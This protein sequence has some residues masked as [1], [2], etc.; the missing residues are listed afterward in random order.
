MTPVD[1]NKFK[2]ILDESGYD[3][4]KHNFSLKVSLRVLILGT[5]VH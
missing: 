2:Q 3:R 4:K 5:K 1:V